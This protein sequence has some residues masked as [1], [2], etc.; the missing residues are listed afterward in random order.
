MND[1]RIGL[2]A[3]GKD[4]STL[5]LFVSNF[6]KILNSKIIKTAIKNNV[7]RIYVGS[8]GTVVNNL[9]KLNALSILVKDIKI[10]CRID[11]LKDID[12][13]LAGDINVKQ[14]YLRQELKRSIIMWSM[15]KN[16]NSENSKTCSLYKTDKII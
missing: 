12:Y 9:K 3:E 11:L 8:Q 4:K 2:E 1:L 15:V 16:S 5:T 13:V 7:K 6:D 14:L 10:V